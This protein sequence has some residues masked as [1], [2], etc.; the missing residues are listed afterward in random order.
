MK[1][2]F[3]QKG[4]KYIYKLDGNVVR[5]SEN[6]YEYIA[7]SFYN[8]EFR[9][10]LACGKLNTCTTAANRRPAMIPRL[11]VKIDFLNGKIDYQSYVR[12]VGKANAMT[13][14][15]VKEIKENGTRDQEVESIK[16]WIKQLE[17][18]SEQIFKFEAE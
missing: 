2:T 14:K 5:T 3:T 18:Y 11:K 7:V 13:P 15:R 4:K 8:G 17:P 16:R 10:V 1:A 9:E 12:M 6:A